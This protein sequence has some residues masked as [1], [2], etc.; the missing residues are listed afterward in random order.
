MQQDEDSCYWLHG[1]GVKQSTFKLA[2][3]EQHTVRCSVGLPQWFLRNQP[4]KTLDTPQMI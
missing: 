4:L 1:S 2:Q 3:A